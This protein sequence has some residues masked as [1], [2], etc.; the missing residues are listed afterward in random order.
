MRHEGRTP[1]IADFINGIG[2]KRKVSKRAN[3]VRF[4]PVSD[5]KADIPDR[6]LRANNGRERVQQWMHQKA[7]YWINLV[8]AGELGSCTG[9]S[10]RNRCSEEVGSSAP[11][12]T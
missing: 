3:V 12:R 11:K 1:P 2:Q 5:R 6:Q 4:A 8:G 9:D 7:G 10:C